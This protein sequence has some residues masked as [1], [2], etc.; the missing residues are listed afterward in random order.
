MS[1][2]SSSG[3]LVGNLFLLKQLL[4]SDI[5]YH[6]LPLKDGQVNFFFHN[7]NAKNFPTP[8]KYL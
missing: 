5:Q 4:S 7:C 6:S 1:L 3:F 2:P 8:K